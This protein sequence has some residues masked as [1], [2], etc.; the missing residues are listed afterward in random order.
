ML[1]GPQAVIDKII[2]DGTKEMIL[3][4]NQNPHYNQI[5]RMMQN[6][7]DSRLLLQVNDY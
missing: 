7:F 3:F 2:F 1:L 6:H 4:K 5:Q